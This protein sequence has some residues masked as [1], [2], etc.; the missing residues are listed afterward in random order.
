[1]G[2]L[3][4]GGWHT[5]GGSRTVLRNRAIRSKAWV[6]TSRNGHNAPR[7]RAGARCHAHC[8]LS[9]RSPARHRPHP[10]RVT[11]YALPSL[12]MFPKVDLNLKAAPMGFPMRIAKRFRDGHEVPRR[13]GPQTPSSIAS[14]SPMLTRTNSI[15]PPMLRP[16]R[17]NDLLGW[18]HGG[19][20][21]GLSAARSTTPLSRSP[22]FA[23]TY[24]EQSNRRWRSTAISRPTCHAAP[25]VNAISMLPKPEM[26]D[27]FG[28]LV[29]SDAL[30]VLPS[31]EVSGCPP[32]MPGDW[33][34]A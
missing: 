30:C 32:R 28:G 27:L 13:Y 29:D 1:M 11:C 20:P 34:P 7:A 9:R 26:V 16:T 8:R 3:D 19:G 14:A 18:P 23:E 4:R 2:L 21:R 17:F 33:V 12:P 10:P 31:P 5:S 25:T 15:S 22:L 24:Q 6:A